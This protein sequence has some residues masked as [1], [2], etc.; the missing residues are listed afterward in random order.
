M[1]KPFHSFVLVAL[2]PIVFGACSSSNK[3][4]SDDEELASDDASFSDA[5]TDALPAADAESVSGDGAVADAATTETPPAETGA[6]APEVTASAPEAAMSEAPSSSLELSGTPTSYTVSA[7]D[8]LM[9]IAYETYGDIYQWRKIYEGNKDKLPNPNAVPPGTVLT[10]YPP[11]TPVQLDRNGEKYLIKFGDTLVKISD[12]VYGTPKKWRKLW[13]NNSKLIRDPNRIF[14]GFYL[15][16]TMSPEDRDE[17]ERLKNNQAVPPLAHD[18][19]GQPAPN[20]GTNKA[21]VQP[22]AGQDDSSRWPAANDGQN[23]G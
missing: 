1:R 16:Y 4:S 18:Q 7:G 22:A 15:Y 11:A 2:L 13:E 3:T 8:T 10:I 12:D 21:A 9:K 5:E 20:S 14:A 17:L 19:Q 6:T 23:G